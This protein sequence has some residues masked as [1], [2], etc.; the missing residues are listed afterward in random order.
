MPMKQHN[1]KSPL[2]RLSTVLGQSLHAELAH[3]KIFGCR[4]YPLLCENDKPPKSAKLC[5][6]TVIRYLIS[7]ENQNTYHIWIPSCNKVIGC[8]DI[9]FDKT[10]FF[11]PANIQQQSQDK[12]TEVIEFNTIEIKPYIRT[13]SKEKEQ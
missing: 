6:C 10:K 1:W 12:V 4:T 5:A 3:L 11:K 13:I 9:T 2:K 8:R 7:Y